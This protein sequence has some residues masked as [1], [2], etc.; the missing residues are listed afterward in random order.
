MVYQTTEQTTSVRLQAPAIAPP[1][2]RGTGD[3]S[4]GMKVKILLVG[5]VGENAEDLVKKLSSLQRSKAGP[6][7][8]CFSVGP[9]SPSIR[10][11]AMP[12][13][14]YLQD[15]TRLENIEDS[16]RTP[17]EGIIKLNTNLYALQGS[18]NQHVGAIWNL[19]VAKTEIT[20]V[21]VPAH[22]RLDALA[23]KTLQEK[24]SHVS[25]VGCDLLL[26]TEFPQ[27]IEKLLPPA[28][29]QPG[30]F[31]VA[32]IALRA[33]ARYHVSP[34][35]VFC[36]SNPFTHLVSSSST[37]TPKHIGRF[38][39]L[40]PVVPVSQAKEKGKPGKYV[41][42]LGMV[43]LQYMT[44]SELDQ[45]PDT[46]ERCPFTDDSYQID[47]SRVLGSEAVKPGLSEAHARR[48]MA[49][50]S[51][52][53][54]YRWEKKRKLAP[55]DEQ[56]DES[57][58]TL[59]LHGLHKDVSGNLQTG[60]VAL[61]QA[62]Q[63][64]GISKVRRPPASSS[65]AF[66]EFDSHAAAKKCLEET[67]GEIVVAGV[68][69]TIKW[70]TQGNKSSQ[71]GGPPTKK[72]RLTEAEAMNSFTLYFSLARKILTEEVA[73]S[74][75]DLRKLMEA[76]LEH[77]LGDPEVTAAAEEALQV[78]LRIVDTSKSYGFLDFAS[79]AAASM[80][81]ASL[82]G[83]TDGGMLDGETVD[84]P[85][86]PE[87]LWGTSLH[88]A[89]E[90]NREISQT[91]QTASGVKFDRQHFPADSRTDC[92]FCLAS[93][94]CEKHLITSVHN[95][96]YIAMPKGPIHKEGHVLIVPVGHS[97][98]GALSQPGLCVELDALKERL[99]KHAA[100]KL[101]TELFIFERAIQTKGG[102][103]THVQCVPVPPNT[104]PKLQAT[105]M[106]MAKASGFQIREINSDI[107][108][109]A[110]A[111]EGYFY[112]EIA[113]PKGDNK[114]FLYRAGPGA[115]V[116]LQFGREV[117]ASVLDNPKLAHW[118]ACVLE[119]AEET[120]LAMEFRKSFS[121]Y[122]PK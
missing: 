98:Q 38:I 107:G 77:A 100:D 25:Y 62:F 18:T 12:L 69:L 24:L 26:T 39:C 27:G 97:S 54:G 115:V 21:S 29:G 90:K 40:A 63:K 8:A 17:H 61:L 94:T 49:A 104:G 47:G 96:C 48:L 6:F 76:T 120:T 70:A 19:P 15:C 56:V 117:I 111:E 93:P 46:L 109:A 65:Y 42:A 88:W 92:W 32:D 28:C 30:S 110:M 13:P 34:H 31:D 89:P 11:H 35:T 10:D 45:K 3:Q 1:H 33:R 81:M 36:Q 50:E 82:T 113:A 41:H 116:P 102:Y 118:K 85:A 103:H 121:E 66:V 74:S 4:T 86:V 99:R 52:E 101:D 106:G 23:T 67:A 105:M 122:E 119:E 22:A 83:S 53:Q 73:A 79:H 114:R 5:S 87:L 20:V 60:S 14:L 64:Y 80:A 2:D 108:L 16:E 44:A 7:D 78:K 71:S 51:S 75:E 84:K 72:H 57:I 43:P 95:Q 68:H 112:A 91:M 37:F 59:F 58:T 55:G 9:C